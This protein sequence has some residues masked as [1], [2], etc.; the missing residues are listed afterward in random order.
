MFVLQLKSER[1]IVILVAARAPDLKRRDL[2]GHFFCHVIT[3]AT[4]AA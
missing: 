2:H 1:A 3:N 4:M